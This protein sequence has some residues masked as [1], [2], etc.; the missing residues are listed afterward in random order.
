MKS[1]V[2]VKSIHHRNTVKIA[3]AIAK[4]LDAKIKNPQDVKPEEFADYDLI[5]FGSG[6]YGEKNHKA[7][8]NL[9]DEIPNVNNKKAFIFSTSGITNKNKVAKDHIKLRKKLESKGYT[10]VDEFQCKGY[11]TNSFLKYIGGMNKG[12]PNADDIKKAEEF[13]KKLT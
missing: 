2:I 8:L 11:N 13:A 3:N 9:A 12:R 6:I 4:I 10:I 7:L 1:L 5:G